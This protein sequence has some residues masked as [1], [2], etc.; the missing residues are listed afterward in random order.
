MVIDISV[1][2]I[3]VAFVVLVAFLTVTLMQTRKTLESV[4]RDLHHVSKEA[5]ELMMRLD[6]LTSDVQSKSES[7]NFVFRPLK[8]INKSQR[9]CSNTASEVATWVTL[10]VILFEKIRAAVSHHAK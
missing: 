4:R 7:L 2:I 6:A 8:E 9:E 1:I 10:S 3:A 5:V